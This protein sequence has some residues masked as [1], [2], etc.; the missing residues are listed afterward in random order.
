M[1]IQKLLIPCKVSLFESFTPFWNSSSASWYFLSK[2]RL[3]RLS[4][5]LPTFELSSIRLCLIPT[6][7]ST[8]V[9]IFQG[10]SVSSF[11]EQQLV[12]EPTMLWVFL[13]NFK[14][15]I[16][17][18]VHTRYILDYILIWE[19]LYL[20]VVTPA[21]AQGLC[22]SCWTFSSTGP[23]EGAYAIQVTFK[24]KIGW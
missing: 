7:P 12:I 24:I 6:S 9:Y 5:L 10:K 8:G 11:L 16:V 21:K 3:L 4:T 2:F 17:Q 15:W 13:W 23:I 1:L 14:Y 22:G 20:G 19:P 18:D